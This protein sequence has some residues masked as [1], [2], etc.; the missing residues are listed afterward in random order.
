MDLSQEPKG[1]GFKAIVGTIFVTAAVTACFIMT[2]G[3]LSMGRQV[4]FT[5]IASVAASL[6]LRKFSAG[7]AAIATAVLVFEL[8]APHL[9]NLAA[10]WPR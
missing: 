5:F 1:R 4:A 9:P 6:L 3:P 8:V 7:I 2:Q 10:N